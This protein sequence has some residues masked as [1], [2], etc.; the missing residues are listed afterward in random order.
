MSEKYQNKL[1]YESLN[2]LVYLEKI[3][4]ET[5]RKWPPSV[6]VQREAKADYKVPNSKLVIEKGCAVMI[7][8]Y[9]IH[10]DPDIYPNPDLFDPSRFD[11]DQSK[12]RHTFAFLPFGEGPRGWSQI[13][14]DGDENL[15]RQAVDEL[16]FHF[17]LR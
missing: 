5:L 14:S 12:G 15:P 8:V 4:K 1:T 13:F 9:G 7:P 3:V 2:E 10:H 16:L 11:A 17:G 6:S